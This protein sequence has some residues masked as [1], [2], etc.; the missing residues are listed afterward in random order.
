MGIKH[1]LPLFTIKCWGSRRCAGLIHLLTVGLIYV[2]CYPGG[3]TIHF[4]TSIS[5]ILSQKWYH[6]YKAPSY[7]FNLTLLVWFLPDF[8][9]LSMLFILE[10][11]CTACSADNLK[12]E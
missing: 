12:I 1:L 7:E 6:I 8:A 9:Y 5:D 10:M 2:Q 11:I 4:S 3:R